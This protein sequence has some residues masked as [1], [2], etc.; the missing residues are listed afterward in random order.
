[1]QQIKAFDDWLA[2]STFCGAIQSYVEE[3]YESYLS[4]AQS[5]E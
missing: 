3:L 2:S 5:V 1:M 4:D